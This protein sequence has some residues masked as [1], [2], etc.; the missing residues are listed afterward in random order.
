MR[1]TVERRVEK[2][3]TR[4]VVNGFFPNYLVVD[5]QTRLTDAVL[6][7]LPHDIQVNS[8]RERLVL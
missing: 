1:L 6:E 2:F 8:I 4:G 7:C 5:C 3:Y